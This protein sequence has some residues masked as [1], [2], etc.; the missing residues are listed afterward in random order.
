MVLRHF[1]HIVTSEI[2]I[3]LMYFHQW[4]Y[5]NI[6]HVYCIIEFEK[7][8]AHGKDVKFWTLLNFTPCIIIS[9][10]LVVFRAIRKCTT[11]MVLSVSIAVKIGSKVVQV[12]VVQ[13]FNLAQK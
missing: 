11:C 6:L 7:T 9:D 10:V 2:V 4:I 8:P 13:S 5:A 3:Y 12:G 1:G